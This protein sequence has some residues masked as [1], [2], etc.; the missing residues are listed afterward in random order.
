LG[1]LNMK[2]SLISKIIR[3][4]Q[5]D[6]NYYRHQQLRTAAMETEEVLNELQHELDQ[7]DIVV[8]IEKN[9]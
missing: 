3:R 5:T 1:E 6:L 8:K 7:Y 2:L 9:D 4:L